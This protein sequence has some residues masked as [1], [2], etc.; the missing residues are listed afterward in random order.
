[1]E[2]FIRA[3]G[4]FSTIFIFYNFVKIYLFGSFKIVE[5]CY[6]VLITE[7]VL[8]HCILIIMLIDFYYYLNRLKK[9]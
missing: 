6:P 4:L 9:L 7:L 8:I 5:P 2:I 1:M 3:F